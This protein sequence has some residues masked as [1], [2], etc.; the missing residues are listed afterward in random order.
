MKKL[1][2]SLT[3]LASLTMIS[4]S[5]FANL[6]DTKAQSIERY[7][8]ITYSDGNWL[9]FQFVHWQLK[10]WVNPDNSLVEL[11]VW[12]KKE[13]EPLTEAEMNAISK[14]NLPPEYLNENRAWLKGDEKW[15]QGEPGYVVYFTK[16]R[17]YNEQIGI[18][19]T[20]HRYMSI[21][22]MRAK[23]AIL[24]EEK[25]PNTKEQTVVDTLTLKLGI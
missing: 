18:S 22:T 4:T 19:T 2:L 16:D 3:A 25:S 10:E 6:G 15:V 17:K 24:A 7:G 1:I 20:G 8:E 21:S 13:A 23:D 12:T 11:V 14:D 9:C 5:A